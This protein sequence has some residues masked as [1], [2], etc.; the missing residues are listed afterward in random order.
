VE[1][2][3]L[4]PQGRTGVQT[5]PALYI[6]CLRAA[7]EAFPWSGRVAGLDQA[8]WEPRPGV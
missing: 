1:F 8:G 4:G 6:T 7:G 2:A 5:R 3:G